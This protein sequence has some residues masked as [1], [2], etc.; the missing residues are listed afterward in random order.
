MPSWSEF[1]TGIAKG[2]PNADLLG[3]LGQL[4]TWLDLPLADALEAMRAKLNGMP[5]LLL[6]RAMIVVNLTLQREAGVPTGPDANHATQE[7]FNKVQQ[8]EATEQDIKLANQFAVLWELFGALLA[9]HPELSQPVS[10]A[11]QTKM[12]L[13]LAATAIFKRVDPVAGKLS[14]G[15]V[16]AA[17]IDTYEAVICDA[18]ALAANARMDNEALPY[19]Y[20]MMGRAERT[21]ANG[22][23]QL[24]RIADALKLFAAA[25]EDF[26]RAGEPAEAADCASR[27]G[28]LQQQLSGRLDTAAETALGSLVRRGDGEDGPAAVSCE[29]VCALMK[30]ADVAGTAADAYEAEQ[31]AE[32]AAKALTDLGYRD[33]HDGDLEAARRTGSPSPARGSRARH[34]WAGSAKSACSSTEFL[35]RGSRP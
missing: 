4:E 16:T 34:F 24:G 7:L 27:A 13:Q 26:T 33:P 9:Q 5:P 29:R 25:G 19:V 21:T 15:T 2:L 1:R 30:L 3:Q 11:A 10:A 32:E 23:I 35:E 17:A 18:K 6:Y 28:T 12:E 22:C 8:N 14:A 20:S 31:Y